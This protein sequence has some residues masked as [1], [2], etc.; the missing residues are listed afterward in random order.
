MITKPKSLTQSLAVAAAFAMPTSVVFAAAPTPP[1]SVSPAER[2][3]LRGEPLAKR[4]GLIGQVQPKHAKTI[5]DNPWSVGGETMDRGYSDYWKWREYLGALGVKRVRIQSGW[6]RTDSGKGNYNFDWIAPIVDDMVAQGVQPW[7]CLC[8]GNENYEGGG[9]PRRDSP[10]PSGPGLQAWLNYVRATAAKFK[11]KVREYELWNEPDLNARINA[12]QYG[13]FAYETAKAIKEVDPGAGIMIGAFAD[14]IWSGRNGN[15]PS[16]AFA[17]R[18]LEIIKE[19]GGASLIQGI[20]FHNYSNNPDHVHASVPSFRE[21]MDS[22]IPGLELRQGESGAPSLN[23]QN[24]A[25]RNEWWTEE[26]QAKYLLRRMLADW[27]RGIPT[28][29]FSIT[30]MHFPVAA[31]TGLS[32]HGA[33]TDAP[34]AADSAKHFKGLLETRLY[35]PDTPEDDKTVVRTK[36]GYPAMQ[37]VTSIFDLR[38]QPTRTEVRVT[39][40]SGQVSAFV[41][42]RDDGATVL[43]VWRS[44]DMPGEKPARELVD[45]EIPGTSFKP[46]AR[47]VDLLTRGV[48]R[49]TNVVQNEDGRVIIRGLPIY[50]SPVLVADAKLVVAR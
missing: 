33:D 40:A 26:S 18:T 27:S 2:P 5:A 12:E 32:W 19:R 46:D 39:G 29:V 13:L 3:P 43:A 38:V 7:M 16:R 31:E 9:V 24:Y 17:R 47:Y 41:F 22:V 44:G 50:D 10:L 11:G 15:N 21:L 34:P 49:M 45:I 23:Q 14:A 36:M 25:L 35:A 4:F 8:Y 28:S 48:Y 6:Q 37:A 42:K 1:A 30:E 20:T